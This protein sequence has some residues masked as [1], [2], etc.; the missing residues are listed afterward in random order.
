MRLK[1]TDINFTNE[2]NWIFK[3]SDGINEYYILTNDFYEKMRIKT[4]ISKKEL[5]YLDIGQSIL[6]EIKDFE[7]I[8]IVTKIV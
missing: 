8:K 3:L 4:P 5:D 6:C 1:I 2:Y 7:D